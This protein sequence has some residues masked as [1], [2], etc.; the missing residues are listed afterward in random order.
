MLR[1]LRISPELSL[2]GYLRVAFQVVSFIF[3]LSIAVLVIGAPL[4]VGG[5]ALTVLTSSMAPKLPPGTLV[6]IKPTPVSEIKI[7]DVITYQ[8]TSGD[9]AVV[10]HRVIE[11][12][13]NL[14]GETSFVTKGDNNDVADHPPV[15][16]IQ[17]KGALWY[18][19]PY[20]GWVNSVVNGEARIM[21]T[22]VITILLF[23]YACYMLLSAVRDIRRRAKKHADPNSR[24]SRRSAAG[25]RELQQDAP[26]KG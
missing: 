21:A 15:T 23:G 16:A 22:P 19:V 4:L 1:T 18:A 10:S 5:Q 14:E 7:G 3:V 13:V 17:V 6:V 11:R 20:L 2:F 8:M 9:P 24:W 25:N 26:K 12:V